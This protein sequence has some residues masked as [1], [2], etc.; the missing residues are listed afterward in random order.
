MKKA[1]SRLTRSLFFVLLLALLA[2]SSLIPAAEPTS[3][4]ASSDLK[5]LAKDC[6][7]KEETNPASAVMEQNFNGTP[8]S[9]FDATEIG[10]YITYAIDV[11]EAGEYKVS[12][13]VRIHGSCGIA[14][15]YING[16][17]YG[18]FDNASGSA[19]T[20]KTFS[21]GKME[22]K[23]GRNTFKF[24]I[25]K[26]NPTPTESRV[27]FLNIMSFELKKPKA[28]S[29]MGL[30]TVA[31]PDKAST[32]VYT[33]KSTDRVAV[34]PFP[35]VYQRSAVFTVTADGIDVPI[36]NYTSGSY[37]DY[38]YGGFSLKKGPVTV[39]ITVPN[40]ITSYSITPKKLG[41]EAEVN[42]K[43]LTFTLEKDEYLIIKINNYKELV[44]TVDPP[45]TD[46][47][48]AS[49]EGIFNVITENYR[50]D[51]T[52]NA[53]STGSL[54]K[55]IDDATAWGVANASQ[56]V[57]YVPA[58]VYR[59]GTVA[60]K[61][62]VSLYL[63]GGAVLYCTGR[64]EDYIKRGNK[65]SIG[66][67]VTQMI[68]VY[69][70]RIYDPYEDEFKDPA[71]YVTSQNIKIYGRGS[72]DARGR[73]MEKQ[74]FLMQTLVAYNCKNFTSDGISYIDTNIWSIIPGCS[75][76]MVFS[77]LKVLNVLGLHENDA[78]DVDNCKNVLVSNAIGVALDDPFSTKTYSGGTEM[79]RSM[80]DIGSGCENVIFED[81]LSWTICFGYK[82]G[83]GA[84]Y[85]HINIVFRDSV[86]YDCSAGI[87][88]NHKYGGG[89]ID[90]VTFDNI[91]IENCTWTN[92]NFKAW[93][94]IETVSG[95]S[96]VGVDPIAN[97]V[98]S[99]IRIHKDGKG[100]SFITGY[101]GSQYPEGTVNGIYFSNI[102]MPGS[103]RPA[104]SL[105]EMNID[106]VTGAKN[107][108]IAETLVS[109][110]PF[111]PYLSYQSNGAT[112]SIRSVI[113]TDLSKLGG[114]EKV[115]VECI[116]SGGGLTTPKTY[117][118]ILS[119]KDSDFTL[120][121][122][123]L[124]GGK[125]YAAQENCALFGFVITD[126]PKNVWESVTVRILDPSGAVLESGSLQ[127]SDVASDLTV[128]PDGEI[129]S[130]GWNEGK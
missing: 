126:I 76:D 124:A 32:T 44:L 119:V 52:G 74:G 65:D 53:I 104:Q 110:K 10:Q 83:Q 78:I 50:A 51:N 80:I 102:Y 112:H 94:N 19:N 82:V 89:T 9:R 47:P 26:P 55:A 97:V 69:N 129:P 93:M 100:K 79:F 14:D 91:E 28:V 54:Q 84:G 35:V 27:Y 31:L 1:L 45:E 87:G 61:S 38:D 18:E 43:T 21:L 60:L 128:K 85:D 118:G 116:F 34:Y 75:E 122:S 103:D 98:I 11:P 72:V 41:L 13:S 90:G 17:K 4:S 37:D 68:Y 114:M 40:R 123:V 64:A 49:G 63:E 111:T 36:R 92:G 101:S 2:A 3:T 56:G 107:V 15:L 67:P 16:E 99:N 42:N 95:S 46:V 117:R 20:L 96:R 70:N 125:Y 12:I 86:V 66:M 59:V 39:S 120:Y 62:N 23:K 58:G 57:V 130:F 109:D 71:N 33:G 115:T 24:V 77:N 8:F 25:T 30:P 108:Y 29:E 121:H 5:Y 88:I 22:L 7:V 127:Y 6:V 81:C 48:P 105:A 106:P 73:E 113:A